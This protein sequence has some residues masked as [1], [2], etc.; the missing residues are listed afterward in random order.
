M[1]RQKQKK[2]KYQG[3]SPSTATNPACVP[4]K[5]KKETHMA[6]DGLSHSSRGRSVDSEDGTSMHS[7]SE[8]LEAPA[9]EQTK[10]S[11]RSEK[12]EEKQAC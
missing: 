12:E 4:K 8:E 10:V 3:G 1:S 6:R 2:T 5:K 7:G 11:V 9:A